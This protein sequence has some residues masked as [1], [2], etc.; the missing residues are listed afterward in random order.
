MQA[1]G[2]A[3]PGETEEGRGERLGKRSHGSNSTGSVSR[4]RDAE[5]IKACLV[6]TIE[7]EKGIHACQGRLRIYTTFYSSFRLDDVEQLLE[8]TLE[9]EKFLDVLI[10]RD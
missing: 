4:S 9:R 1:L 5:K 2:E 8:S 7:S 3:D 10:L 6:C